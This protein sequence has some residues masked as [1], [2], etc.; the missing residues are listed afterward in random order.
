M[1]ASYRE[2]FDTLCQA[3]RASD[4]ALLECRSADSGAVM[5]VICATNRL[6]TGQTECVRLAQMLDH[7]LGAIVLPLPNGSRGNPEWNRLAY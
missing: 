5:Y 3:I 1:P 7:N 6:A 4:A 2:N